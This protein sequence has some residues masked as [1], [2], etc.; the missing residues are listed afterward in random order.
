[1][2]LFTFSELWGSAPCKVCGKEDFITILSDEEEKEIEGLNGSDTA[3][4]IC[5][6]KLGYSVCS[7]HIPT[8]LLTKEQ[9]MLKEVIDA[10]PIYKD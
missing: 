5:E 8:E 9:D 10:A 2:R 7:E 4:V 6:M 1:M 3:S